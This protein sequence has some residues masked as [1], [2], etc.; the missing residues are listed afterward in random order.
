MAGCFNTPSS[1]HGD[2][3]ANPAVACGQSVFDGVRCDGT[4]PTCDWSEGTDAGA[5]GEHCSCA[6]GTWHCI[7]TYH[8][9]P[10]DFK[11]PQAVCTPGTSCIDRDW[12]HGCDCSCG[13]DS[14]W[15]CMAETIGST[16]VIQ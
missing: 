5:G 4:Q 7:D 16:C 1:T 12:E 11:D 6:A 15:H 8:S 3:D 13:T 2:P 9:C 14:H 10:A